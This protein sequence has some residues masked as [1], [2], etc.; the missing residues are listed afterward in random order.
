[1]VEHPPVSA[2]DTAVPRHCFLALS[3]VGIDLQGA[4][5]G[6]PRKDPQSHN[7]IQPIYSP[8]IILKHLDS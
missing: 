1:M 3:G 2:K 5:G 8:L 7:L 6:T 4:L